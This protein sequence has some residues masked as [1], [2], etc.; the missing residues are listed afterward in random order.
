MRQ[1]DHVARQTAKLRRHVSC[2]SLRPA[3]RGLADRALASGPIHVLALATQA[4]MAGPRPPIRLRNFTGRSAHT[5]VVVNT[6]WYRLRLLFDPKERWHGWH[7]GRLRFAARFRSLLLV[8]LQQ[9]MRA[10]RGSIRR[11]NRDCA[12][13]SAT[14]SLPAQSSV[15]C[16]TKSRSR[17]ASP[18]QQKK[19]AAQG[20]PL[21]CW[22]RRGES[23]PRPKVLRPRI[24]MHSSPFS[25]VPRQHDVRSAP[26]DQPVRS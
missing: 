17:T 14:A 8:P 6:V 3:R 9:R 19:R 22:W 12:P 15:A 21:S 11:C 23:N 5:I 16:C 13:L 7:C 1:L 20:G 4:V 10:V 18:H 25:L 2:M 24:Y 26:K